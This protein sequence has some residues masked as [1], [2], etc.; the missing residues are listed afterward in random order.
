MSA[1]IAR[2]RTVAGRMYGYLNRLFR[3]SFPTIRKRQHE[4]LDLW[5]PQARRVH[6]LEAELERV[7]NHVALT[8][9]VP[10]SSRQSRDEKV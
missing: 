7:R 6:E 10:D 8:R 3:R 1:G 9:D 4:A 5:A 2:P